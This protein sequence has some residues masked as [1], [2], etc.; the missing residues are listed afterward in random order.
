[1]PRVGRRYIACILKRSF[2]LVVATAGLILLFPLLTGLSI[3]VLVTLGRPIF[4]RQ[5]RPG[6]NGRPFLL[7]KFRT[8]RE[9]KG[10][11]S[12]APD[13]ELRMTRVGQS[14]RR[15]SLDDLPELWNVLRG[16]MSL[17]GPRPLLCEYLPLFSEQHARRH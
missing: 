2:D 14:L 1:H 3:V 8:M 12:D 17:V 13:D 5:L 7:V 9:R 6:L 10:S 16:D 4:F 15:W 11:K